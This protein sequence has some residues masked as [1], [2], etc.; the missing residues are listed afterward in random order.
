ME[1]FWRKGNT[2]S[3]DG[4][5][6]RHQGSNSRTRTYSIVTKM[7]TSTNISRAPT[8][9]TETNYH[10]QQSHH[11]IYPLFKK[12]EHWGD[13][14]EPIPIYSQNINGISDNTGLKNDDI[15]KHMEKADADIFSINKFHANKMNTKNNK[16]LEMSQRR[17]FQS[18][19]G[20][21]CNLVSLSS[22]APITSYTNRG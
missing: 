22:L 21:Q 6:I 10:L 1:L 16:V 13:P 11:H 5:R 20:Q 2:S 3:G 19:E 4:N 7:G 17:M 9:A 18:N 14:S 12:N 15:F 8:I